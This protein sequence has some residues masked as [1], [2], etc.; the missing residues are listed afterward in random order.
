MEPDLYV[1]AGAP[2][3]VSGTY[4]GDHIVG[5]SQSAGGGERVPGRGRKTTS[6]SSGTLLD[7]ISANPLE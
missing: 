3:R 7:T 2:A 5:P 1:F 4:A 6:H